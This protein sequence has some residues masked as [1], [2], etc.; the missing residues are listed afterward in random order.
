MHELIGKVLSKDMRWNSLRPLQERSF[1]SILDGHNLLITA[2]TAS[3]KTEAALLPILSVICSDSALRDS[4]TPVGVYIAPLKALINDITLRLRKLTYRSPLDVYA[5]HSDVSHSDKQ[6]ALKKA[7]LIVTTPE[8][9]EGMLISKKSNAHRF[10][11]NL[12]F[13]LIDELHCLINSP[14]GAQLASLI[15]RL[16]TLSNH[17]IQRIAM[18]ATIG[19]PQEILHW[20]KGASN[21][22]TEHI[23]D[24]A[25][26]QKWLRIED[27]S[28]IQL[29]ADLSR[30]M[31]TNG[32]A[33]VFT[34]SKQE[35]EQIYSHIRSLGH[36]CLLHHGSMGK[37]IRQKSEEAFKND[38]EKRI[39][40]ATT[41]L[42]MGIDIG[43]VAFVFFYSVPS[44][45]ASFM[46]RIGRAGRKTGVSRS[47]LYV[48]TQEENPK[49][50]LESHLKLFGDLQLFME[51]RVEPIH[52]SRNYY[53][54]LSH[55]I[56]SMVL[57][58]GQIPLSRLGILKNAYPFQ[59]VTGQDF[60]KM[61]DYL[62]ESEYLSQSGD[63]LLLGHRISEMLT[64]LGI[65]E[66]VSVFEVGEELTVWMGETEIG[67]VH[68]ATLKV[69]SQMAAAG[70]NRSFF[71]SGKAWRVESV[72][73][74]S[75]KVWVQ[76][77][78][79]GI[80]PLWLGSSEMIARRF[81]QAVRQ[82]MLTPHFSES[83]QVAPVVMDAL[84][85]TIET[86]KY[87]VSPDHPW[88]LAPV[89]KKSCVDYTLYTYEGDMKNLALSLWIRNQFDDARNVRWDWK[90]VRFR[91]SMPA[92]AEEIHASIHHIDYA[93]FKEEMEEVLIP[94]LPEIARKL[95]SD[96][97]SDFIPTELLLESCIKNLWEA[98]QEKES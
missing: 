53:Q 85:K 77:D 64:P 5:W 18:S 39:M 62:F 60:K 40:V 17:S 94:L 67:K 93:T 66:F 56:L 73:M 10:F 31:A 15:E 27:Q 57:S 69:L 9:L 26:T 54:I 24:G 2:G 45:A 50:R 48:N 16:Q 98:V 51:G 25:Q 33:I 97:C 34:S 8:S 72:D 63:T 84:L 49:K 36:A 70:I 91:S 12:R 7:S 46:Q 96:S 79:S 30:M 41:T 59:E 4:H 82:F 28:L 11:S 38:Q 14:R 55:Q 92:D 20:L 19:N 21:R 44:S 61:M 76:P 52:I 68:K 42:E 95:F 37:E 74:K 22:E 81:S 29:E 80:P 71:L 88:T 58:D 65:G 89:P 32:K 83:I 6:S 1:K 86:L 13:I 35:A 75:R 43:D 87:S 78:K 23:H 3:G 90:S 47:V